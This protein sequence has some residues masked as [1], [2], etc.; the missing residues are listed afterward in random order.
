MVLSGILGTDMTLLLSLRLL[1]N[2]TIGIKTVGRFYKFFVFNCVLLSFLGEIILT[3]PA[4]GV[5][6][7]LNRSCLLRRFLAVG[8][9]SIPINELGGRIE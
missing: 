8:Y 5:F 6:D 4:K 1:I 7:Y 2:K 9:C 3:L